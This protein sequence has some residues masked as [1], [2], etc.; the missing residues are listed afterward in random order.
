MMKKSF[1]IGSCPVCGQGMLELVKENKSGS[2][3]VLCDECEGEWESPENALSACKGSRGKYGAVSKVTL[4]EIQ[5]IH[6][7]RY[8]FQTEKK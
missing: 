3:F 7:D 2:L 6:W 1:Y 4:Q 5:A 8:L